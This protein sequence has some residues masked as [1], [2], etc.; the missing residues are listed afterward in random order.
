MYVYCSSPYSS[1]LSSLPPPCP[2]RSPVTVIATKDSLFL[3][4]ENFAHWPLPR[5]QDLVPKEALLP[6][7]LDVEQRSITDVEKIVSISYRSSTRFFLPPFSV[8]LS[9]LPP[10][11]SLFLSLSSSSMF[12]FLHLPLLPSLCLP[13]LPP[14]IICPSFPPS[15]SPISLLTLYAIIC[16]SFTSLPP[17]LSSPPHLCNFFYFRTFQILD[18]DQPKYIIVRFFVEVCKFCTTCVICKDVA[19]YC[20]SEY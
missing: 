7:F 6:P 2:V 16:P 4:K 3:A 1:F 18:R 17:P 11:S 10:F 8:P 14:A 20:I 5:M 19:G 12:D 9:F 13:Y 15:A